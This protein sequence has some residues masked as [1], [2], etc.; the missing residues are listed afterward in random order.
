VSTLAFDSADLRNLAAEIKEATKPP[1]NLEK[2][3]MRLYDDAAEAYR[4]ACLAH[5]E[6][7]ILQDKAIMS[8]LD[9]CLAELGKQ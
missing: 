5:D 9:K 2:E 4:K 6:Q 1:S 3:Y 8:H 7:K